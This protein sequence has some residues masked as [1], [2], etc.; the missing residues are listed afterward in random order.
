MGAFSVFVAV[1]VLVRAGWRARR[2]GA[3]PGLDDLRVLVLAIAAAGF[4]VLVTVGEEY[5]GFETLVVPLVLAVAATVRR[6]RA[7]TGPRVALALAL[8]A[9]LA[10]AILPG[11]S[12][13]ELAGDDGEASWLLRGRP[14]HYEQVARLPDEVVLAV[15]DR[16]P[17]ATTVATAVYGDAHLENSHLFEAAARLGLEL[18]LRSVA[19]DQPLPEELDGWWDGVSSVLVYDVEGCVYE[20]LDVCALD[21]RLAGAGF[22]VVETWVVTAGRQVRLWQRP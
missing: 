21:A 22:T 12:P 15:A 14:D 6:P 3:V 18:D 11:A 8:V 13:V 7:G 2:H 20:A 16:H 17:P 1:P 19:T 4:V 9:S 10:L 5:P